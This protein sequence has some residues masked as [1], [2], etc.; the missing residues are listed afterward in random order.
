MLQIVII[1][2]KYFLSNACNPSVERTALI[3]N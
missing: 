1:K 3:I 2:K